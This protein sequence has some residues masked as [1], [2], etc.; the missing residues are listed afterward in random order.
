MATAPDDLRRIPPPIGAVFPPRTGNH[1]EPLVDG[2]SAFDRIAAAVEAA[3]TSVMVCV[4][5]LE[6]DAMFPGGLGTFFD[7]MDGAASRGVDVRVLFWHPESHGV[8]AED[9]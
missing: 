6:V 9:T 2:A 4:A 5:F 7:L 3:T 1:V 8:G